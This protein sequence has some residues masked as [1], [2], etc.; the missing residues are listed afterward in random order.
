MAYFLYSNQNLYKIF[1]NDSFKDSFP[2]TLDNYTLVNVSDSDFNDFCDEK[3]NAT[4]TDGSVTF[5]ANT[6]VTATFESQELLEGWLKQYVS[7]MQ[8]LISDS[9][10][11]NDFQTFIDSVNN[12]DYS[13]LSYPVSFDNVNEYLKSLGINTYIDWQLY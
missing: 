5:T 2:E 6:R 12:I 11:K 8:N 13:S 1:S 7:S 4:F 10:K 9:N 3:V